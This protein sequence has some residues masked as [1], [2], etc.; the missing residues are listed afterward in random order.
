MRVDV[1]QLLDGHPFE[2]DVVLH[3]QTAESILGLTLSIYADDVAHPRVRVVDEGSVAAMSGHFESMDIVTAINGAEM[4]SDKQAREL[5]SQSHGDIRFTVRRDGS[6][7]PPRARWAVAMSSATE[8]SSGEAG[9]AVAGVGPEGYDVLHVATT[10]TDPHE[11]ARDD[12]WVQEE[13]F[14]LQRAVLVGVEAVELL[15]EERQQ[16][17]LKGPP[18]A[19]KSGQLGALPAPA[20]AA[21]IEEFRD[22]HDQIEWPNEGAAQRRRASRIVVSRAGGE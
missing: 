7:P 16:I 19:S 2:R 12:P 4:T 10:R 9:V 13:L 22:A 8:A 20:T 1:N 5:I 18:D 3:K 11:A 15:L 14:L 21:L 17:F 6:R